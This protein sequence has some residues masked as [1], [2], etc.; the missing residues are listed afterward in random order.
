MF[1][2]SVLLANLSFIMKDPQYFKD[3]LTFNPYRFIDTQGNFIKNERVIPFGV[4]MT[5]LSN[6]CIVLP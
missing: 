5:F 4:G 3:P 2:G 6:L 1:Q